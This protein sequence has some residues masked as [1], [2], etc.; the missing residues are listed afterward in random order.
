MH[1]QKFAIYRYH[2]C[3]CAYVYTKTGMHVCKYGCVCLYVLIYIHN[4]PMHT[5]KYIFKKHACTCRCIQHIKYMPT[6]YT[7]LYIHTHMSRAFNAGYGRLGYIHI[8]IHTYTHRSRAFSAG[9]GGLRYIR[10]QIRTYTGPVHLVLGM[11]GFASTTN[12]QDPQPDIFQVCGYVCMY[13]YTHICTTTNVQDPITTF[14]RYLC[15]F[16][17]V[18]IY[19]YIYIYIYGYI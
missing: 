16:I 10:T 12:V 17:Y 11:A 7:H 2:V 3:E 1:G 4:I 13:V 19:I 5:Y 9:Y 18:Y 14:P 15:V 8:H 6:S